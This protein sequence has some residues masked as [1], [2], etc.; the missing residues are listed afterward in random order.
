[1]IYKAREKLKMK[2]QQKGFNHVL[3]LTVD[4]LVNTL[5][6]I[7]KAFAILRTKVFKGVSLSFLFMWE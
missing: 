7:N 2:L 4:F 3:N 5:N 6:L 1:M